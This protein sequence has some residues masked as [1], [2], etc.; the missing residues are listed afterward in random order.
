MKQHFQIPPINLNFYLGF[1]YIYIYMPIA[2]EEL[3]LLLSK[4]NKMC[5]EQHW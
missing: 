3:M 1:M 5:L 4:N 2:E